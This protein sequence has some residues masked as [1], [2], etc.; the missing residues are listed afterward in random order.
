M[1]IA[2]RG[3]KPGCMIDIASLRKSQ[4]ESSLTVKNS[5]SCFFGVYERW[6]KLDRFCMLERGV[7]QFRP[8]PTVR[9]TQS[10]SASTQTRKKVERLISL[11]AV[12]SNVFGHLI[13]KVRISYVELHSNAR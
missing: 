7:V 6:P 5:S 11:R 13:L 8:P 12:E 2:T 1:A 3:G 10:T 9:V 4:I